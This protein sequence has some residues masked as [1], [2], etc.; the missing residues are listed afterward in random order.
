MTNLTRCLAPRLYTL[1]TMP[2]VTTDLRNEVRTVLARHNNEF[3]SNALQD[4]KRMDSFLKETMRVY[5]A[6]CGK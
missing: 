1:V 5:P 4:M 6:L 2:D 3:T